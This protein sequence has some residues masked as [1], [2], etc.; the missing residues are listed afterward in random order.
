MSITNV[1]FCFLLYILLDNYL[2]DVYWHKTYLVN[3]CLIL[4]TTLDN[5]TG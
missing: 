4:S 5:N 3:F 1:F 2:L